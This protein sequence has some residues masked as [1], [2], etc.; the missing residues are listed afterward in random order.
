MTWVSRRTAPGGLN[1]LTTPA[2]ERVDD[3]SLVYSDLPSMVAFEESHRSGSSSP[4]PRRFDGYT[5][6]HGFFTG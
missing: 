4:M 2:T 1:T 6:Y 3:V 5:I